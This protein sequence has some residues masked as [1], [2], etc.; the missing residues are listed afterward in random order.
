MNR[1]KLGIIVLLLVLIT[2]CSN[3]PL[4]PKGRFINLFIPNGKYKVIGFRNLPSSIVVYDGTA[5]ATLGT[6][7]V[8]LSNSE[9]CSFL[10]LDEQGFF[11]QGTVG[12]TYQAYLWSGEDPFGEYEKCIVGIVCTD[13]NHTD[14]TIDV[15]LDGKDYNYQGKY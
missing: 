8:T 12:N 15:K 1:I 14:Y 10:Y 5:G 9:T 4:V 11:N 6:L 13:D 7:K 3:V 2:S